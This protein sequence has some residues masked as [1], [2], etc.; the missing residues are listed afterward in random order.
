VLIWNLGCQGVRLRTGL[1]SN[2]LQPC[3]GLSGCFFHCK[4]VALLQLIREG[5]T[6]FFRNVIPAH[7]CGY[8]LSHS[9]SRRFRTYALA[10]PFR[11]PLNMRSVLGGITQSEQLRSA[12]WLQL[13]NGAGAGFRW[14]R[15]LKLHSDAEPE[16]QYEAKH[17][18]RY[19]RDGHRRD[20]HRRNKQQEG[21]DAAKEKC[22]GKC[23]KKACHDKSLKSR[24]DANRLWNFT[25]RNCWCGL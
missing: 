3:I 24:A 17:E 2:P 20:E 10:M 1:L 22:T 16:R 21:C 12:K 19:C 23:E 8:S 5:L 18:Q 4:P 25:R 7:C 11:K 15:R 14:K 13:V 6:P 9:D